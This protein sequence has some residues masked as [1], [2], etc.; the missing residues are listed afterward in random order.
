MW[1]SCLPRQEVEMI[2]VHAPRDRKF[3]RYQVCASLGE[4]SGG[5]EI[6]AFERGGLEMRFMSFERE[7]LR[8][9]GSYALWQ[10]LWGT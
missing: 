7:I 5:H 2:W 9:W 10:E 8:T 3:E 6:H 4:M 1:S